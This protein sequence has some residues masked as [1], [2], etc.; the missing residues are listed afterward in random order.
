MISIDKFGRRS[1]KRFSTEIRSPPAHGFMLTRDGNYD[2]ENKRLSN[3]NNPFDSNDAATKKYVDE[4]LKES[5]P[6]E[7]PLLEIKSELENQDARILNIEERQ[8]RDLSTFN[9]DF[10]SNITQ[11][12]NTFENKIYSQQK[13]FKKLLKDS[14]MEDLN[15]KVRDV[16]YL[17][18]NVQKIYDD[19]IKVVPVDVLKKM[20]TDSIVVVPKKQNE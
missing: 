12:L 4:N 5:I 15:N 17:I 13:E 19:L 11:V 18:G 7:K 16:S 6:S 14:L 9:N 1:N 3:L 10:L 2:M 20:Y 8:F